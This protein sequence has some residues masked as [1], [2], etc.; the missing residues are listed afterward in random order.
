MII[1]GKAWYVKKGFDLEKLAE[2]YGFELAGCAYRRGIP[3]EPYERV[4]VIKETRVVKKKFTTYSFSLKT[5]PYIQD[6]IHD[7]VVE[8]GTYYYAIFF[9][10]DARNLS[11]RARARIERSIDKRQHKADVKEG[12]ALTEGESL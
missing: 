5:A 10:R 11:E 2:K 7:G 8:L 1:K 4:S 9:F 3:N 6:L 12:R